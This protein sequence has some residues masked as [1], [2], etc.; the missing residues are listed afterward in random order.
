MS[1]GKKTSPPATPS[2][3]FA[4][5]IAERV[6][7]WE[8]LTSSY[9]APSPDYVFQV[10]E[11]GHG[12][13]FLCGRWQL[14]VTTALTYPA[15]APSYQLE[16]VNEKAQG[17]GEASGAELEARL[18]NIAKEKRGEVFLKDLVE[19]IR[20]FV[21]HPPGS[22]RST[23][24]H[25]AE[26]PNLEP[27]GP[28]AVETPDQITAADQ[29][30]DEN[31]DVRY[32]LDQQ[33]IGG[34]EHLDAKV[35]QSFM[36]KVTIQSITQGLPAS[37]RLLHAEVILRAPLV[38]RFNEAREAL[39]KK[40]AR[41]AK[42][43]V[44][45]SAREQISESVIPRDVFADRFTQIDV[46]YYGTQRQHVGSIVRSGF[47]TP[48][49]KI[50]DGANV[51]PASPYCEGVHTSSDVAQCLGYSD[52][53]KKG[54]RV[55][56]GQKVLVCAALLGKQ[57]KI[58]EDDLQG[59]CSCFLPEESLS[60]DSAATPDKEHIIFDPVQLLPL[61]VLHLE[62]HSATSGGWKAE[63]DSSSNNV[64]DKARKKLLTA[65]A[66]KHFPYGFGAAGSKFVVEEIASP[67]DDEEEW[68]EHQTDRLDLELAKVDA[69]GEFQRMRL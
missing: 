43:K 13:K 10:T 3:P 59:L 11:P 20:H 47:V 61:Y 66:K 42:K 14:A 8:H 18:R 63:D 31:K 55:L 15:F 41:E 24:E 36:G 28:A 50:A 16:L 5:I 12:F 22:S 68:G 26:E 4:D 45:A 52:M 48:G 9:S 54:S 29:S 25:V 40:Y 64:S 49:M 23:P 2:D 46:V 44:R 67:Q 58:S 53:T 38:R 69:F 62:D 7:E 19:E 32:W 6:K 21:Q 1:S 60:C 51:N 34:I 57:Y 65:Q 33:L 30:I 39:I 17:V 35:A 56:P 37:V 27:P